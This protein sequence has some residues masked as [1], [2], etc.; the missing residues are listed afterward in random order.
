VQLR[1]LA[2][3]DQYVEL[4]AEVFSGKSVFPASGASHEGTGSFALFAKTGADINM[5]SSY[6]AGL[7]YLH[8]SAD[9]RVTG[10]GDV[11]QGDTDL[12]IA[13]L[14]YKWGAERQSD[15]AESHSLR[16]VVSMGRDEG[17][18]N[19]IDF[20]QT[21]WGWY[22]QGVYQFMPQW[23]AGLRASGLSSDDPG[24]LLAGSALDDGGYSP[25][26]LSALLEMDTS[27]FGRIRLEYTHDEAIADP[28]DA[29]TLQYTVIY[30]PHGAHR[31]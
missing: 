30:G 20:N 10:A 8:T 23:S 12:G 29:L 27:E 31:Y 22:A 17:A 28:N 18:F 11:F 14:V 16:R 21:H 9:D 2:P 3:T 7:S 25:L 26:E 15:D 13:T 6:L 1:W 19:A 5:S 24:A 4:G